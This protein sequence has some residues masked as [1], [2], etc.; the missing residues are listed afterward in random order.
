MDLGG[1]IRVGYEDSPFMS[2]G[3]RARNNI[4]L[5]EDAVKEAEKAGLKTASSERAREI[6]GLKPLPAGAPRSGEAFSQ[7]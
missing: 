3:K 7:K 1:H 2:N 4:E 5:V 6:I